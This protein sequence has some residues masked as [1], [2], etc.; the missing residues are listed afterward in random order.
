MSY[1]FSAKG[2]S[3]TEAI[4]DADEKFDKVCVDMPVHGLDRGAVQDHMRKLIDIAR[5][6]AAD[7]E[8]SIAM[9]GYI[10]V[11]N[12]TAGPS[13]V[14]TVAASCTVSITRKTT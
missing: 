5:D 6:P 4:L 14:S 2:A 9:S 13:G 3:K 10:V 1:S 11:A 7:E 8:V 12:P